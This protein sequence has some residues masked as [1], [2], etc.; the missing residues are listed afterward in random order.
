YQFCNFLLHI[1][2]LR[3][4]LYSGYIWNR[5]GD[6]VMKKFL[7]VVMIISLLGV[8]AACGDKSK[9]ANKPTAT[10]APTKE[11][12]SK[13]TTAQQLAEKFKQ[14]GLEVGDIKK[15][16]AP[17][18]GP[19]PKTAKEGVRILVPSL[20]EDDGGRL[21]TFDSKEDLEKLKSYYDKLG[22]EMGFLYSHTYAKGDFLLQMN[23]KMNEDQFK[24]YREVM[25]KAID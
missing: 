22:K 19:A 3:C 23:G 25:E 16:E 10:E 15:M 24:K 2:F 18:Y 8:L 12:K 6:G 13:V 20:G 4:K 1:F 21:F 14:E 17:D 7:S 9:E 11:S 5:K